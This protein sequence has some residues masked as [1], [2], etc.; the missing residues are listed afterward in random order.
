MQNYTGFGW[1]GSNY[2]NDL[3]T[4]DI[5]RIIRQKLKKHFPDCK[6]SVTSKYYAGGS[7]IH[8]S[9][10]SA[11]FTVF[12]NEISDYTEKD[13]YDQVN[14]YY[15]DDSKHYTK[16][17]KEVLKKVYKLTQSFNYDDSDGQI[18]YFSTNFYFH[19]NI[20]KWDKPFVIA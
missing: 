14:Q 8:C 1:E 12:T 7:S 11:P 20:G 4:K 5:A 10:M 18:D 16:K 2:N 19:L 13:Q 17:A 9:L 6:F 15:I 3:S